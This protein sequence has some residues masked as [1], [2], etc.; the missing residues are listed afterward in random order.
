MTTIDWDGHLAAFRAGSQTAASYC[1]AAGIKL[2]TFRYH[3]YKRG[4]KKKLRRRPQRFQEFH[5]ATELV[6]ARDGRGALTISGFD[7][8]HLPQIVGA[9]S[10]ALS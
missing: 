6:I 3:L 5:V 1:D 9:W 10:N 2:G 8:T 4:A 7:V